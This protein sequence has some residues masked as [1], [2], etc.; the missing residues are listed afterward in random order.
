MVKKRK[1][2]MLLIF[3][4]VSTK[5]IISVTKET[6]TYKNSG[7]RYPFIDLMRSNP[8]ING[9]IEEIGAI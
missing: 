8:A 7:T 2:I 5:F 4:F 9:G 3:D 6:D 1:T